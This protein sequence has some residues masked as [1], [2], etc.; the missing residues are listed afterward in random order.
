MQDVYYTFPEARE[1]GDGTHKRW[2]N[3]INIL[4]PSQ[5]PLR[6]ASVSD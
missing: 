2:N 5:C 1:P 6:E 3:S 4:I